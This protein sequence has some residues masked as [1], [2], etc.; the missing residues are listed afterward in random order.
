MRSRV[1]LATYRLQFNSNFRYESGHTDDF[2]RK[3]M[4]QGQNY[5]WNPVSHS[6]LCRRARRFKESPIDNLLFFVF[7]SSHY[8][9]PNNRE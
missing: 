9:G 5:A 4:S 7:A 3:R 8:D 2:G 1:P 6:S